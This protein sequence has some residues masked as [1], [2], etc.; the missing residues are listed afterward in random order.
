MTA[1]VPGSEF[2]KTLANLPE[3]IL[4]ADLDALNEALAKLFDKLRFANSLLPGESPG[5]QGAIVA[6]N[7]TREFLMRFEAVQAETLGG[8]LLHLANALDALNVNNIQPILKSPKRSGRAPSSIA[9]YALI[10]FGVGAAQ[11][12]EWTG[13]SPEAADR[14]VAAKLKN[15]GVKPT[16]GK[17][18]ITV[19]TLRGWREHINEVRPRLRSALLFEQRDIGDPDDGWIYAAKYAHEM[20]AEEDRARIGATAPDAARRF[21][22]SAL[23]QNILRNMLAFSS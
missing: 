15:L 4:P 3:K 21:I 9:R 12:L 17:G 13:L 22:L 18:G 16:R 20:L 5:R 11:R 19:A 10:G 1:D 14:T 8:P 6:L 7:A 23:E 2:G